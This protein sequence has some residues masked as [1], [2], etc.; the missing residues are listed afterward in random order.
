MDPI[1]LLHLTC[2]SSYTCGW[3]MVSS[4]HHQLLLSGEAFVDFSWPSKQ[5]VTFNTSQFS[6]WLSSD[7]SIRM[8]LTYAIFGVQHMLSSCF[9]VVFFLPSYGFNIWIR[10]IY[11]CHERRYSDLS[12]ASATSSTLHDNIITQ[13]DNQL[14]VLG[15]CFFLMHH[16]QDKLDFS[17]VAKSMV[18]SSPLVPV[19]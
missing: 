12:T 2:G 4:I 1:M 8:G 9:Y 14:I 16:Y 15:Y 7:F 3:E 6:A 18:W 10:F 13:P 5:F 11:D 19:K 17:C